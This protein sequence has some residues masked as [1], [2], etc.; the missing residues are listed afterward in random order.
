M[1]HGT[2]LSTDT[3]VVSTFRRRWTMILGSL[4]VVAACV[5]IRYYWEADSAS[6]GSADIPPLPGDL[7]PVSSGNSADKSSR[8]ANASKQTPEEPAHK[9]AATV[10]GE[11]ITREELA[12]ECLRHYGK[13][14]LE[15]LVNKYLIVMECK[16][17]GISVTQ[18]EVNAEIEKL[19]KRFNLPADQWLKML[20]QER[21]IG[22]AQ[23]GSDIIWPT[24]ALRKLAGKRLEITP[25]DLRREYERFYGPSI[26]VLMIVCAT[27]H[28]AERARQEALANPKNFGNV[29]KQWS[30]D[31]NTASLKGLVQP[32]RMHS[33][34]PELEETVFKMRNG[35]IS[36]VIEAAGQFMVVLR[37][38]ELPAQN[39]AFEQVQKQLEQAI[40]DRKLRNVANKVF[41]EL[42]KSATI[43]NVL[44]DPKKSR[45]MPGIAA[46][47]NGNP[48]TLQEL[49]QR[50][51]E[52][53]G[54]EVLEGAINHRLIEQACRK[55]HLEVT[56]ADLDQEVAMAAKRMVKD[57]EDGSPDVEAW[58]KLVT[59]Q[60]NITV[61]V[62]RHDAVWPSVALKKL[63]GK[64]IEIN[65]A[66][67]KKGYEANYGPR[68]RCLAIVVNNQRLATRVW[69]LARKTPNP[70]SFARLA[71]QYS[72]DANVRALRGEIPPIQQ[73]GGQPL[74]EKEAFGLKPGELSSIIQ[75][76]H[77]QFAILLCQGMTN[78]GKITFESV[79]DTIY[80]DVLDK[81]QRIA[82]ATCF[83]ELKKAATIDNYVTNT[84][85]SPQRPDAPKG[86]EP[87][88]AGSNNARAQAPAPV[89]V[90]R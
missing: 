31:P 50:C 75:I 41:E 65:D 4:L 9:F 76:D 77:D 51:M 1:T 54:E 3:P 57:R 42:Q 69:E 62:Y 70:E 47:I 83:E 59:Q 11:D 46:V 85:R 86:A 5:T 30:D 28:K 24:L 6:A 48:V 66:D 44:N 64:Q 7:A 84:S 74:L 2:D 58:L 45:A 19:A 80:E 52:R 10:N 39:I 87:P 68:V 79:H 25:D 81:K 32:I 22:P 8:P 43:E 40:Q 53:H 63:V 20:K 17:R 14:V 78:P 61:D 27:R 21:G 33:S 15:S 88:R 82:M 13:D 23:Y 67:L 36:P 60:Q 37:E 55:N 26:K 89:Q 38:T 90:V 29:A 12:Q 72:T 49:A 35:E 34:T 73:H 18:D 71:E 56:E 16:R